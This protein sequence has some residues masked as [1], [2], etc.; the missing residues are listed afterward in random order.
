[1]K[2]DSF[3]TIVPEPN[4]KEDVLVT[5]VVDPEHFHVQFTSMAKKLDAIMDQLE[6]FYAK[7][8]P[9]DCVLRRVGLGVACVAKYSADGAWYR[10]KVTGMCY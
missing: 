4:T 3:D 8:G 10:A 9:D 7:L 1:M 6:E 5:H 2:G